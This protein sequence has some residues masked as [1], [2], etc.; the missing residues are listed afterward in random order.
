MCSVTGV[1]DW[2]VVQNN[3]HRAAQVVPHIHFHLIPRYQDGRLGPKRT[4]DVGML[5][6]WKMFGRGPREDLDDD[7]GAE[8][9][10]LLREAVQKEIAA[11][12][13]SAKL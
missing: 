2:N 3:G 10:R 12:D 11:K 9:A 6:S 13:A 4:P 1:E 8:L 7:E 5:K